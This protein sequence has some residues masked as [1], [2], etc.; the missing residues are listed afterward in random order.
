MINNVQQRRDEK[1]KSA[2]LQAE[3]NRVR[4]DRLEDEERRNEDEERAKT[5][6]REEE[7]RAREERQE[8]NKAEIRHMQQMF[9][10]ALGG[11]I[12]AFGGDNKRKKRKRGNR[13]NQRGSSAE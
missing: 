13:G 5:D 9:M 6:G 4:E 7:D 8:E 3:K 1:E 10:M 2:E 12:N 11:G